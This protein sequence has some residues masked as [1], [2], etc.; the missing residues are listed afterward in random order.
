MAALPLDYSVPSLR[1]RAHLAMRASAAAMESSQRAAA[2]SAAASSAASRAA[3]AAEQ[4][5][6]AAASVQVRAVYAALGRDHR[7]AAE[8][9]QPAVH[10]CRHH[11]HL[12]VWPRHVP[13]CCAFPGVGCSAAGASQAACMQLPG[14]YRCLHACPCEHT[15]IDLNCRRLACLHACLPNSLRWSMPLKT[16]W[17]QPWSA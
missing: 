3:E 15:S 1:E 16:P 13:T 7:A 11:V 9:H 12:G 10:H 6:A 8:I 2:Y 14:F 17:H 5:A 4:S